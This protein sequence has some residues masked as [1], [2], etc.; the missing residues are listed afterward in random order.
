MK[1]IL[2]DQIKAALQYT[3]QLHA[4][5]QAIKGPVGSKGGGIKGRLLLT[6]HPSHSF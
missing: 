4:N 6:N 2:K 3:S 1:G 5:E